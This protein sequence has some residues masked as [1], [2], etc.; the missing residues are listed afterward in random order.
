MENAVFLHLMR[1]GYK[2][3]VG[4]SGNYEIDFVAIKGGTTIYVQVSYLVSGEKTISREFGNLSKISNNY[5]K[6]V[7]TM[8]EYNSG[9]NFNG[10]EEVHL[11][12]FLMIR[13]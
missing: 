8:D 11:K 9:R 3:Y 5:L 6:Y 1:R 12:E 2:V 10:I 7:V 4:Q 13:A